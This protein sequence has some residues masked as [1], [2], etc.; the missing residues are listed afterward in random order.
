MAVPARRVQG[1]QD[2][3]SDGNDACRPCGPHQEGDLCNEDDLLTGSPPTC[4]ERK[5]NSVSGLTTTHNPHF[6]DISWKMWKGE[7]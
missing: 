2:D 1:G 7:T 4:L 5:H 3:E 6:T